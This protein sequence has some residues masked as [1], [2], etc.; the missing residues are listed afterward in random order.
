MSKKDES[1]DCECS[2]RFGSPKGEKR[3][4]FIKRKNA[5][6]INCEPACSES[7]LSIWR[8]KDMS[9]KDESPDCECS[10]RFGSPK[11]EKRVLFIKKPK[12]L[13]IYLNYT[14]EEMHFT[15]LI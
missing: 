13:I 14:A 8:A 6:Q 2:E 10:E 5:K 9:K 15:P 4:L 12:W 3:V 1:P 7:D 11:G